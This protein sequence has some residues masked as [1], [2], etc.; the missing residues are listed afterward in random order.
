M[1]ADKIP[2]FFTVVFNKK[3]FKEVHI[4]L[5][6]HRTSWEVFVIWFLSQEEDLVD[7]IPLC[8]MCIT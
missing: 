4:K 5:D 6:I 7:H 3:R 2:A 1:K 8:G